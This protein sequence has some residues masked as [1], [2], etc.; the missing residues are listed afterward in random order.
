MF[1]GFLAIIPSGHAACCVAESAAKG[2]C[3]SERDSMMIEP[4]IDE[5]EQWA[6]EGGC[7]AACPHECWVEPDGTCEHGHDSWLLVL[8]LI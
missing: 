1:V 3:Y 7:V 6:D 4:T 8:G 2:P 5:M